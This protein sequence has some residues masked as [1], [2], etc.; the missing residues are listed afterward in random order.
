MST[1]WG[2]AATGLNLATAACATLNLSYFL[3]QARRAT[4]RAPR[5]VAAIALALVSL[6]ALVESLLL[7]ALPSPQGS[8]AW[9]AARALPFAGTAFISLLILRS[10]S[11]P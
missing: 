6:G 2:A 1:P 11:R 3:E 10:L 8:L 4:G 5:R 7:L 9:M